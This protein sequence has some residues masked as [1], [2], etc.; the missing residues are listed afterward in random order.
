MKTDVVF[1]FDNTASMN[2]CI[3]EVRRKV[4]QLVTGLLADFPDMRIGII[5]H[6]D[7]GS[8]AYVTRTCDLTDDAQKLIDFVTHQA[9]DAPNSSTDECYELV[10]RDCQ[11]LSWRADADNRKLVLIGDCCPHEPDDPENILKIDWR[12]ELL[13][14][15]AM[16]VAVYAVHCL[17]WGAREKAFYQQVARDTN[18]LYLP[19]RSLDAIPVLFQAVC[20]RQQGVESLEMYERTLPVR[21]REVTRIMDSLLERET[22]EAP[23]GPL[24]RAP[25]GKY[26][27][28]PVDSAMSIK[29]FVEAQGLPFKTGS[30]YYQ[31]TKKEK[32][33][34]KKSILL[35][36]RALGDVY[37]GAAA[38][39][40][41]EEAVGG[42]G[43][44]S[45]LHAN[46]L[47]E[48][49]IFIQSTS[50]TRKLA[51]GTLFIY[52]I[53]AGG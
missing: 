53:L 20:R 52:E 11:A 32:I 12:A 47:P 26:Q 36:H 1:S 8:P 23:A 50:C 13:K 44:L 37:E 6:G 40:M 5:A 3:R 10:L 28:I 7:Y 2:Q 4:K 24:E 14:L 16:D 39:R 43:D 21:S 49:D 41:A 19:L 34:A 18:G 29:L 15:R 51:S 25:D 46:S 45:G 17:D 38:R 33:S 9:V 42:A 31:L 27:V 22:T 48:Y 35:R 30:G